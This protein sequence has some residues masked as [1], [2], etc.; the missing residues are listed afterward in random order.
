M[1]NRLSFA[2]YVTVQNFHLQTEKNYR[3]EYTL[4]ICTGNV[5]FASIH[6][7]GKE[8][9]ISFTTHHYRIVTRVCHEERFKLTELSVI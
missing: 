9:W 2:L 7:K 1:L 8:K 3:M 5:F 4:Q 6:P